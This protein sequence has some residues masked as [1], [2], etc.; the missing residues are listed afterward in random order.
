V[1]ATWQVNPAQP[2]LK[3][4]AAAARAIRGGSIVAIPTDTLYALAADPFQPAAVTEIF[5]L[6]GRPEHKPILLLVASIAQVEM[7]TRSVPTAFHRLAARFWPGP[8][9]IILRA[10]RC[11][12]EQ[13]TAGSGTIAVRHPG[14]LL[15]RL[16]IQAARVPLTGTSANRS[17]RPPAR[18][19]MQIEEQFRSS[20]LL[21]MDGGQAAIRVPSTLVD[22]TGEPRILREGAVPAADVL[23]IC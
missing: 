7:L 13:V 17:G 18:S 6:K 5:R 4:V 19:A 23:S 2:D 1:R 8:L 22:L 21:V 14:L 11:I 3:A 16:L 9:T 15:T 12:P 20:R 10:S